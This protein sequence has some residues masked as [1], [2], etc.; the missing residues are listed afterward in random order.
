M[1]YAIARNAFAET[2]EHCDAMLQ[3]HAPRLILYY[4]KG[5]SYYKL[6]SKN[7]AISAYLTGIEKCR[8]TAGAEE[9]SEIYSLLGDT[10]YKVGRVNDAICAYDSALV[11]NPGNTAVLNNYAYY[12]ALENRSLD[13]AL[14]MSHR[15]LVD[16]PDEVI[17]IDTYAWILFLQGR[18]S[19]ALVYAE[20][21]M[22]ASGE[23]SAVEY[24]HCGDIYAK[25][26]NMER[27]LECWEKAQEKGDD[28]KILKRK[29]KKKRYISNDKKK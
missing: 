19:D 9:I 14:E 22:Q 20:K 5:I 25:N 21:L 2:I 24:H 12:L 10:Y 18:Y 13:K 11:Y 3:Y 8:E 7:D 6:G 17:Y 4:Y 1:E 28:S 16:E 27:A 26:G 29:I 23:H 15:T